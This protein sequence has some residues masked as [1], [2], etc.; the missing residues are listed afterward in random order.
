MAGKY[1]PFEDVE[2]L[3]NIEQLAH[4]LG[5]KTKPSGNQL[6]CSC[7]IHGGNDRALAIT[8]T[9][10]SKRGSLGV[11]FCQS[12]KSGGDRIGLVAHCMDIGQQDAAF[13]IAEQFGA[14]EVTVETGTVNNNA[15]SKSRATVPQKQEGGAN[16]PAKSE[17]FD[18]A[19]FS[20]R[21][22]FSQEVAALGFTEEL[23]ERFSVG[24]YRGK[25]Y[26]PVRDPDGSISGFVGY[27]DGALKL[28]PRWLPPA[29]NIVKF[30]KSA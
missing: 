20:A 7:P 9:A 28:P 19:A 18:P 3:A 27:G 5:L 2:Q 11:F 16:R 22:I 21:L 30:P 24:F 26:I 10:R 12:A 13:F 4:R 15:A 25:V 6:R 29:T 8:P 14:E 23:A 17:T 1:L